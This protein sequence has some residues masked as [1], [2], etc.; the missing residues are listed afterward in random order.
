MH[1]LFKIKGIKLKFILAGLLI[2][3]I[4]L[5]VISTI[6]YIISYKITEKEI[7]EKITETALKFASDLNTFFIENGAVLHSIVVNKEIYDHDDQFLKQYVSATY[8]REMLKNAAI[9]DVYV[10]FTD[11][12]MITG[13]GWVPPPDYDCR[14][15][16][17]YQLAMKKGSFVYK[18]CHLDARTKEMIITIVAGTYQ[19]KRY[20]VAVPQQTFI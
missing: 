3:I 11:R 20:R 15:R 2:C 16:P 7:N 12:K 19:E 9:I 8:K 13:S 5:A 6:S 4:S 14:T 17:W 1:K 10:G 18:T